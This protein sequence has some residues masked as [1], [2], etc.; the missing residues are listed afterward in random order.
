[1]FL[2]IM[3]MITICFA[4]AGFSMWILYETAFE[5]ERERLIETA[6][7]QARLIEAL[8]D[9]ILFT[10]KITQKAQWQLH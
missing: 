10:A 5:E 2:L 6:Q 4:V 1:M 9:S 3:I 8:L 7:S